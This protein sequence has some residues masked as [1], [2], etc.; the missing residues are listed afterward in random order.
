M[1]RP[2][3][4]ILQIRSREAGGGRSSR[5]RDVESETPIEEGSLGRLS[6]F[7]GIF[8]LILILGIPFFL[9]DVAIS[10]VS[11]IQQK[12][13]ETT[14]FFN[15]DQFLL[16]FQPLGSPEGFLKTL[17]R[18]VAEKAEESVTPRA[19]M[20]K[21]LGRLN[22][23]YPGLFTFY[24]FDPDDQLVPLK[25]TPKGKRA[26]ELVMKFIKQQYKGKVGGFEGNTR[27]ILRSLLGTKRNSLEKLFR[28]SWGQTSHR[29]EK[30]WFYYFLGNSFSFFANIHESGY[31]PMMP[32]KKVIKSWR[33]PRVRVN[34][35][36]MASLEVMGFPD[37]DWQT[38]ILRNILRLEREP[39]NH[40][41]ESGWLCATLSLESRY[42]VVAAIEDRTGDS[43]SLQLRSYRLFACLMLLLGA[44]VF[45]I[46]SLG[47]RMSYVSIRLKLLGVFLFSTGLPLVVLTVTGRIYLKERER[48]LVQENLER[49]RILL[50][51]ID[52]KL[53]IAKR[54]I[55]SKL[56]KILADADYLTPQGMREFRRSLAKFRGLYHCKSTALMDQNSEFI[57]LKKDE[58]TKVAAM[59]FLKAFMTSI[60]REVAGA[61]GNPASE[62]SYVEAE[63]ILS[64]I[65]GQDSAELIDN[66]VG[67]LNRVI[68]QYIGPLSGF[69]FWSV[70]RA[71]ASQKAFIFFAG[72]EAADFSQIFLRNVISFKPSEDGTELLALDLTPRWDQGF[73]PRRGEGG[74]GN[75]FFSQRYFRCF[76]YRPLA[77]PVKEFLL[78]TM[79]RNAFT[80]GQVNYKGEPALIA[81]FPGNQLQEF[82]IFLVKPLGPV[83]E[84]I[85]SLSMKLT[86]FE[87]LS[88][89]FAIFLGTVLARK[90]LAPIRDLSVG[91]T[92]ARQKQFRHRIP[93]QDPDELGDLAEHFNWMMESLQEMDMA[94]QIQRQLFP[95]SPLETGEYKVFGISRPAS[96]LGGDYFDYLVFGGGKKLLVL[97][98]D[99][100]GHGVPSALGMA[101]SKALIRVLSSLEFPDQV[102][103]ENLNRVLFETFREK[104]EP[105]LM[106]LS[107]LFLDTQSNSG[108]FFSCGHP[109]P[110]RRSGSGEIIQMEGIGKPMGTKAVFSARPIPISM[111]PGDRIVLY[112][113]GLVESLI[114]DWKVDAFQLFQ[115]H[116]ARFLHLPIDQACRGI[117]DGH[118]FFQKK[119]PQ[120]DDFT[121]LIL[122]RLPPQKTG[123]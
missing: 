97:L 5:P 103:L 90:F 75:R 88:L 114:D 117:L 13:L 8:I 7:K 95:G 64:T 46:L 17:F 119:K 100:T 122:E 99:V 70:V 50:Y 123:T 34:L 77:P 29:S 16:R 74:K 87:L 59:K 84:E 39:G 18:K 80:Y 24:L 26:P 102:I 91:I 92:A 2:R 44:L 27:S 58:N 43:P 94:K 42:Y 111:N 115:E 37:P 107:V 101:M 60:L 118:P 49:L 40:F 36:D 82:M 120:P 96:D 66:L 53:P 108:T 63:M 47:S 67:N 56:R 6:S 21:M 112:S 69:T 110:Y 57:P 85:S 105:L 15:L 93:R 3:I 33:D 28:S 81:G 76:P 106:T 79:K 113:D 19:S 11:Q 54:L 52:S 32:L 78:R 89:A 71:R 104:R 48:A 23:A 72:W 83:K 10:Y 68:P 9:V 35:V 30:T 41:R 4:R 73:R 65:S 109:F 31:P 62:K 61:S 86:A 38:R 22:I 12:N 1:D 45:G 25:L 116:I 20:G 51:D 14:S 55:E 98:G 121:V